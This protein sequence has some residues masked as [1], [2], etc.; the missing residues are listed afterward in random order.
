MDTKSFEVAKTWEALRDLGP[1]S[2]ATQVSCLTLLLIA[3]IWSFAEGPSG[4]VE[5][6]LL[7]VKVGVGTASKFAILL[8][9][10]LYFLVCVFNSYRVLLERK[11]ESLIQESDPGFQL[12]WNCK[13]PAVTTYVANIQSKGSMGSLVGAVLA[14]ATLLV[15]FLL[16]GLVVWLGIECHRQLGYWL[17]TMPSLVLVVLGLG[18]FW[19]S[20]LTPTGGTSNGSG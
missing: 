19:S 13:Y 11:V 10:A 17:T 18:I 16:L 3:I 14:A 4:Q 7:G 12:S 5:L 15:P 9:S 2:T 8:T 1:R 6:P 20:E